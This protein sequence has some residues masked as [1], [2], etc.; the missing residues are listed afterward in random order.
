M[1]SPALQMWAVVKRYGVLRK[2]EALRGVSL[3]VRRG[4]C[5]GLAGPNGAG[6]TT[7]IK[8]LLGLAQPDEGEVR[9][10]GRRPDDPEVRRGVGFVPESAEL[11]PAASPRALVRRFARLR[12]LDTA[13][14]V[15]RGIE[16]LERLE[17]GSLLDRAAG[18]LSKGEKQRTLLALALMP[19]P[20][21]LILDEPTDGLDPLGRALVRRI[22]RE[23]VRRG[24]TVFL[25]SHLL[26]ETERVCTR[27]AILHQGRIVRE[28]A[29]SEAARSDVLAST[30]VVLAAPLAAETLQ[31]AGARPAPSLQ[32]RV[33]E[34]A[35]ATVLVDH[36]SLE[37]LN[38]CLDRL[39]AAGGLIEEVRRVRQDLEASFEAAVTAQAQPPAIAADPP[40]E[41]PAPA[42]DPWRAP[43]A[44]LRVT[45]EIISDLTA[46]KVGWVAL[47]AALLFAGLFLWGVQHE[48]VAGTAA[49][50]RRWAR[51]VSASPEGGIGTIAGRYVAAVA[52]WVLVPGSVL[53]AALFAPPLLDPRRAVLVLSQPISRTDFAAG[54]YAAVC[55]FVLAGYAFAAL[56]F[57]G[58]LRFLEIRAD[59]RFLLAPLPML[60]AFAAIYAA[61][62]A[63]TYALRSGLAAA[64]LGVALFVTSALL[65]FADGARPAAELSGV[66][67]AAAL[68][69][70]LRPLSQQAMRIGGAEAPFVAPFGETLLFAGAL[71]LLTAWA[72]RRSER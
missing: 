3:T 50:A 62:L 4:E 55:A 31:A 64:A 12:G 49:A 22:L 63:L 61:E 51:E 34:S 38:L 16:Q 46:R 10:F 41:A 8:L 66:S 26:S 53:L 67:M 21:L 40:P 44:V 20:D 15:P 23:E 43:S 71:L 58:G 52:F 37:A 7:L 24:G 39:R 2:N 68:L 32:G 29:I 36:H 56:L 47:A 70:R 9:L 57:F 17:M 30:A 13:R 59:P 6:K 69:P 18:K 5:F 19:E 25:N 72:A 1:D 45:R 33:T 11:P 60:V 28:E 65:G 54:I 27:V 42:A 14:F 48:L 35:G